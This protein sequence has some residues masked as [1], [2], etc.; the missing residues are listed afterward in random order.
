VPTLAENLVHE[1]SHQY[2]H[3]AQRVAPV[4]SGVDTRR[5][6]SPAV[7]RS[8]PLDRLMIA[9]HAFA[10]VAAF[11]SELAASGSSFEA[12]ARRQIAM[13]SPK[14]AQLREPLIGNPD[15]TPFGRALVR[16]VDSLLVQLGVLSQIAL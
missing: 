13:L 3:L 2:F 7:G 8:R 1:A 5:Y 15:V 6:Y 9:F 11:Y 14:L 16:P 12:D 4:T 10:N